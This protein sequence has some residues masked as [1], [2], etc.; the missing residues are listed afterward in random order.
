MAEQ[1]IHMFDFG[2]KHI[3]GLCVDLLNG[4]PSELAYCSVLSHGVRKGGV[5]NFEHVGQAI[6]QLVMQLKEKSGYEHKKGQGS[7]DFF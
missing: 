4:F 2:T 7:W 5:H 1:Y 6:S 3:G